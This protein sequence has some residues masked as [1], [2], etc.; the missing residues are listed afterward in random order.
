VWRQADLYL[1]LATIFVSTGK[2]QT[3]CHRADAG[4]TDI[5]VSL[6]DVPVTSALGQ[7]YLHQLTEQLVARVSE[8]PHGLRIHI[9]YPPVCVDDD[10]GIGHGVDQ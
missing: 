5:P 7:Q 9:D 8:Q 6:T 2:I 1:E 10:Y 4:R 3:G